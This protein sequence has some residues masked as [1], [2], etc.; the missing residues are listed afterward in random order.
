MGNQKPKNHKRFVLEL[1]Q[2]HAGNAKGFEID[3]FFIR[4]M[5]ETGLI[6]QTIEKILTEQTGSV[7]KDS[8]RIFVI[9]D[10]FLVSES[11]SSRRRPQGIRTGEGISNHLK[12]QWEWPR[13][14]FKKES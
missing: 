12:T 7:W 1:L 13:R 11:N 6:P 10:A 2:S 4:V 8:G 5:E 14:R 3:E 9:K